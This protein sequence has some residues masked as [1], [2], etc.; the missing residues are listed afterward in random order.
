[1]KKKILLGLGALALAVV[2]VPMFAAF[3]AHVINVTATIENALSVNTTP[4]SFGTVFPQEQLDRQ[5]QV[6]LSASFKDENRVDNVSYIIRQK[7]KCAVVTT[8]NYGNQTIVGE[9]VSGHVDDN[10]RTICPPVLD[11]SGLPI[12]G[13]QP[14]PLLCPY[15]SKHPDGTP[16]PNDG[17]L[18]AFHQ[19][20]TTSTGLWVWND[21]SGYLAK[22]AQDFNDTWNLDLK[23]PCFEGNCA[24]DWAK[25][26]TDIN[27][28]A[29]PDD[30]IQ[31]IG[32][33][34]KLFG[35]DIW[36]E[37]TGVNRG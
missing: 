22:S 17:S 31:P 36:I 24:Q 8:D 4:I 20:G 25:Y 6:A 2:T 29:N 19:I 5:I 12:P 11:A 13:Y 32:N 10:G 21:V 7:P 16:Y 26:V 30:Y 3:E 1:M 27:P 9:T 23:V 18:D 28:S 33:E 15:L 34:H 14:L 37:V 35:C